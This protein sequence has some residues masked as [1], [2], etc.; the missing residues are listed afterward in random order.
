MFN[1]NRTQNLFFELQRSWC[2][3]YPN[4]IT[5]IPPFYP[6][7]QQQKWPD[8]SVFVNLSFGPEYPKQS[9]F[10]QILTND[11]RSKSTTGFVKFKIS[12][13]AVLTLDFRSSTLRIFF[14]RFTYR[15][16]AHDG[17]LVVRVGANYVQDHRFRSGYGPDEIIICK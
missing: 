17:D 3:D 10:S 6:I 2:T 1:R 16:F 5:L 15:F 11:F 14:A 4:S 8:L 13:R 7:S 12:I 9:T